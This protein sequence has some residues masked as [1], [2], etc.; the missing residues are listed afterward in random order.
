[1]SQTD[2]PLTDDLLDLA[3]DGDVSA[4]ERLMDRHRDRLRK[5]VAVRL[6]SRLAARID[7]SD[8]VQETLL[9]ATKRLPAYLKRRPI[10]FY[11]W[12]RQLAQD[13]LERLHTRHIARQ[14]RAID[15]EEQSR[16]RLSNHSLLKLASRFAAKDSSPSRRAL[17]EELRER[18]QQ[19][20]DLMADQDREV[21]ILRFLEQLPVK[22]VAEVLGLSEGAVNMR[23]LRA[24]ERLRTLLGT[25][26][27]EH[28][29]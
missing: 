1:M 13:R 10:P 16:C 5:M 9:V 12:L 14:N 22:E 27:E 2:H 19:A 3:A 29:S 20:L 11:P 7:P 23:Q 17:R 15:R 24:L 8:V 26:G 18:V 6:D 25:L 28:N 4:A 21:L